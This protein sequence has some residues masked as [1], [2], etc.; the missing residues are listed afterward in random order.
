MDELGLPML[1][2]QC[3]ELFLGR[4]FASMKATL[5]DKFGREL[6]DAQ[7]DAMR[8]R[9]YALYRQELQPV[10]GV[11]RTLEA[12]TIPYCVASSSFP[13]RIRLSLELTGL[14][15]YFGDHIFSATMVAHGKPAPDLFLYAAER[16]GHAPVD[17]IVVEDSPA[18]I[19]AAQRAS[20]RPLGFVG[21]SHARAARL[22]DT[23][24]ALGPS[25]IF[26]DMETLPALIDSLGR[27]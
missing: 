1:A 16:M 24:A 12:L 22:R 3:Y 21:G 11:A 13:E 15:R 14:S 18:G 20:M 17:C 7:I 8:H 2:S 10:S 6:T 26:E 4:S 9:L 5:R 19:Q 25:Y 23:I 27:I